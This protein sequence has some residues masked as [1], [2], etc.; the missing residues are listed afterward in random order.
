G[1]GFAERLGLRFHVTAYLPQF[2]VVAGAAPDQ[3]DGPVLRGRHQPGAVPFGYAPDGPLFQRDHQGVL[4]QF[5]GRTDVAGDA[6]EAGDEAGRF[7]PPDRLDRRARGLV[8]IHRCPAPSPAGCR[9][10][11][12]SR[13]TGPGAAGR[14]GRPTRW[15]RPWT[16]GHT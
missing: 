1:V 16:A 12:P 15:L 11:L 14:S 4:G 3:V 2:L 8:L 7:D 10:A 5:L 13:A 6:G 9:S